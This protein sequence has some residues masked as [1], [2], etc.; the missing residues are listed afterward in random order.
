MTITVFHVVIVN[1]ETRTVRFVE[2]A[3]SVNNND[4]KR[5][6]RPW[7]D[8]ASEARGNLKRTEETLKRKDNNGNAGY[9]W[10][11]DDSQEFDTRYGEITSEAEDTI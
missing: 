5:K 3:E 1:N 9:A 8:V 11:S 10:L 4:T 7:K 2:E 6:R